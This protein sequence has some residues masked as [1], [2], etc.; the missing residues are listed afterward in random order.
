MSA[1][2]IDVMWVVL[3]AGLVFLMQA[4]FLCLES[5]L[6]RGRNAINVAIKNVVDFA[7]VVSLSWAFGFALMFGSSAAGLVGTDRFMLSVGHGST[8]ALAAFFLFPA[9]FC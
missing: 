6:T 5:G 3:C 8:S 9:M 1:V 4:G 7:V 2:S